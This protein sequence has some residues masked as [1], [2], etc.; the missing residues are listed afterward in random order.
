M[1]YLKISCTYFKNIAENDIWLYQMKSYILE[2][3]SCRSKMTKTDPPLRKIKFERHWM[4]TYISFSCQVQGWDHLHP[5]F[6][7]G[8]KSECLS[9]FFATALKICRDFLQ[10]SSYNLS[11]HYS[12]NVSQALQTYLQDRHGKSEKM[13]CMLGNLNITKLWNI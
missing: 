7:A 8:I 5:R 11:Q 6:F 1:T 9:S 4:H 13:L 10:K 3:K 2:F 12:A